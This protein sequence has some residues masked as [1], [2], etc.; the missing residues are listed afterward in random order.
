MVMAG[1]KGY[2]LKCGKCGHEDMAA[3]S[4]RFDTLKELA[5]KLAG[6]KCPECGGK[7]TIDPSKRIRF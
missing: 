2:A 6:R 5:L 4:E 3:F 7:M 1:F